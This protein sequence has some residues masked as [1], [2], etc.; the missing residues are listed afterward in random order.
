MNRSEQWILTTSRVLDSQSEDAIVQFDQIRFAWVRRRL[1][2]SR[3]VDGGNS[4]G[5]MMSVFDIW[6]EN[7]PSDSPG[8][9]Q[10]P[11]DS[12]ESDSYSAVRR[13]IAYEKADR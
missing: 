13:L 5:P 2:E 3:S 10:R 11:P 12:V 6:F 1:V 4:P 7:P 9:L 8:D